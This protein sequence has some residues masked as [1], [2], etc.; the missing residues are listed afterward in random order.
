MLNV[1]LH[2]ARSRGPHRPGSTGTRLRRLL[3][4]RLIIVLLFLGTGIFAAAV[5]VL[6][7]WPARA[8]G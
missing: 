4:A 2:D 6:V 8:S 1:L 7:A 3:L 5:I